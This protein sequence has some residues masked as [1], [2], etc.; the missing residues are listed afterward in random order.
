LKTGFKVQFSQENKK[1]VTSLISQNR[2]VYT[3][4]EIKKTFLACSDM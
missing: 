3:L 1:K 4:T 2:E